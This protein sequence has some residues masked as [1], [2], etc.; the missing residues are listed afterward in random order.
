MNNKFLITGATGFVGRQVLSKLLEKKKDVRIIV[1]KDKENFL[2]DINSRAEIV[3]TD[4]LFEESVDWWNEQCKNID[5]II[6]LAW[7]SEPGKYLL[8]SKN[9]ECLNGSLNL[10]KGAINSGV[11]RFVGIGTCFEYDLN[12]GRLSIDTPLKPSSPY[13]AAKAGLYTF[14]SQ[15]FSTKSIEFTWCRLFYIYG[16]GED[17]R[18]LVP[19]I[20]KQ[21][22]KGFVAELSSGKQVRDFLNVLVVGQ[23]ITDVALSQ[24]Q[25]P[26]NICSGTPITVR[27]LAEQIADE[28][29]KRDLL[30]FGARPDNLTDPK[31]V[32][33]VPNL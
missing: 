6:H 10:A 17:D 16:E 27:Q 7:Y 29:G 5:T 1:R 21:L 32:L 4:D 28:Y 14:L 19:Y 26:I 31:V 13:A 24:K 18:R 2:G 11:R 9:I 23:M 33:G 25:G 30:K 3:T 12:A 22:S 15:L 20:R 8:S